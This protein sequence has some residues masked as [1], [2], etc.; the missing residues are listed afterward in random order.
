MGQVMDKFKKGEPTP[1]QVEKLAEDIKP[2]IDKVYEAELKD[3]EVEYDDLYH[4]IF[5]I[6]QEL[7]EI[8]GAMQFEL[9]SKDE[10]IEA[11]KA[12]HRSKGQLTKEECREIIGKM[13]TLD[14]FSVGQGAIDILLYLF[15]IPIC[16]LIAKRI[17]PGMKSIS[18]DVVIPVATSGS[19]IFLAKTNKL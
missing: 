19:V 2:I 9:P 15:G 3:K 5:N 1:V 12:C 10:L 16:A 11:F 7:R 14:G 18:D 17:I 8:N 6:I 4:A 13:I